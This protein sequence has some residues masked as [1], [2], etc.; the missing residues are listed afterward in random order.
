M[1]APRGGECRLGREPKRRRS[2]QCS[3][4]ALDTDLEVDRSI[5]QL[6]AQGDI[7]SSALCPY[8]VFA[9]ALIGALLFGPEAKETAKQSERLRITELTTA[10]KHIDRA[11]KTLAPYREDIER[12][13]AAEDEELFARL[14]DVVRAES[15]IGNCIK[16]LDQ[17]FQKTYGEKIDPASSSQSRPGRPGDLALYTVVNACLS[18][19]EQLIGSSPGKRN[20]KF[21]NLLHAAAI[22][23]LGPLEPEPDW[24]WQVFAARQRQ[25]QR[26]ENQPK[27]QE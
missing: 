9:N 16:F 27:K 17:T 21:Q 13:S 20:R 8:R 18:A 3:S 10:L 24:E 22:T 6:I 23:V 11:L 5:A 19:W 2:E 14:A 7:A 26:A 4:C 15:L 25:V 1:Q 12:L